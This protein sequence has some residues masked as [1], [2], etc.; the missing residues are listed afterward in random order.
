MTN[1]TPWKIARI[2]GSVNGF[3][4][5]M[6]VCDFYHSTAA[7]RIDMANK[8]P[9]TTSHAPLRDLNNAIFPLD[10]RCLLTD[11]DQTTQYVLGSSCKSEFVYTEKG[12]WTDPCADMF[13]IL[14]ESEFMTVKSFAHR[15]IA[16]PLHPAT[17]GMQ[18]KRQAG[19]C[20]E[21]F[22]KVDIDV[23]LVEG[24]ELTSNEA[25][26]EAGLNRAALV[27][28]TEWTVDNGI[29][30]MVE[31]PVRVW[32][33][34]ERAFCYQLDTGPV[35][36]PN[37][38]YNHTHLIETFD[39]AYVAHNCPNWAEFIVNVPT[40]IEANISVDH[41]NESRRLDNVTNRMFAIV[42]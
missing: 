32:N 26:V 42:E 34:N 20:A 9:I 4:L 39:R 3:N 14:S 24:R 33:F 30:V 28:R 7:F 41:Y 36:L 12:V 8:P 1:R 25:I 11:G 16:V 38:N 27:S 10:C 40:Q 21:A 22:D 37:F 18:P 2:H 23:R 19:S 15:G 31:Y 35:L 29:Q 5:S 17:L 13:I 6:E